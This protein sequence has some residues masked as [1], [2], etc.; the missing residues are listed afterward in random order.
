MTDRRE[1]AKAAAERGANVAMDAF[2][3]DVATRE[4]SGKVD[5]VT[6]ADEAAQDAVIEAIRESYPDEPI[7]GE[8]GD[9]RKTVPESGP[10]WIIDPIDGTNN[11]VHGVGR[12]GTAVACVEDGEPV[13]SVVTVP[14]L[15]EQY[16][17]DADGVWLNGEP[18]GVSD[19][20]DPDAFV[21][22][23]TLRYTNGLREAYAA[24]VGSI[25]ESF[26]QFQRVGSTQFTLA[27]LARGSLDVVVGLGE[28]NPWDTVAGVQLIR[29]AG[30]T[31]TD[32]S[33][34]PWRHDSEGLVATNGAAH[35]AVL[36]R[37]AVDGTDAES[38]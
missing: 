30:G 37:L 7:V 36:G 1:V 22:A 10:A 35:D 21:V 14:A 13:T 11:F 2:E 32:V 33:G 19:R 31:V 27:L 20:S 15:D 25:I 16:V 34:E 28:A 26:D 5:V 12:W 24:L 3:T 17:A 8:E 6:E 9:Q 23:V 4:K 29:Q 38:D 18:I